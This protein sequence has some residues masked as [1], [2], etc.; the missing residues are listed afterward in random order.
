MKAITRWRISMSIILC[1]VTYCASLGMG[2]GGNE[3]SNQKLR[4]DAFAFL[5]SKFI[6]EMDCVWHLDRLSEVVIFDRPE[7]TVELMNEQQVSLPLMTEKVA[8]F[9]DHIV[10]RGRR[11]DQVR[12]AKLRL[13]NKFFP[14]QVVQKSADGLE[15]CFRVPALPL[16]N[17]PSSKRLALLIDKEVSV[18][19]V[20]LRTESPF[21]INAFEEFGEQRTLHAKQR[22]E[23]AFDAYQNLVKKINELSVEKLAESLRD[24][25]EEFAGAI[26]LSQLTAGVDIISI[27]GFFVD[28]RVA[29]IYEELSRMDAEEAAD[30]ATNI[31]RNELQRFK[32]DW[33]GVGILPARKR[34]AVQALLF[35]SSEFCSTDQFLQQVDEW[36]GWYQS[37]K[38]GKGF[39]FKYQGRP[40]FLLVANLYAN[41]FV[42]Q[43]ELSIDEANQWLVATLGPELSVRSRIPKL[44][45]RWLPSSDSIP[46]HVDLIADVPTFQSFGSMRGQEK[47][48]R[49]LAALRAEILGN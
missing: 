2:P 21:D 18:E 4:K 3:N 46:G 12:F 31:F 41:I 32:E 10:V 45:Q 27:N 8:R 5:F 49:V 36:Q 19:R 39:Q 22:G 24:N 15:V 35:L 11:L 42:R 20:V 47:Q 14:L 44:E 26:V 33:E 38:D 28:R 9:F 29:K 40:D 17:K 25:T 1:Q 16:S 23:R 37:Q 30:V 34:Y 13:G 7:S 43:H 6:P 48:K